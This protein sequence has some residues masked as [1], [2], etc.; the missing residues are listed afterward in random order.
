[1]IELIPAYGRTYKNMNE[2]K[3]DWDNGLDFQ[4]FNGPYCSIRDINKL[5]NDYSKVVLVCCNE[6]NVVGQDIW[7]GLL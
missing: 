3:K 6:R 7:N 2:A 4:V 5:V 1:M